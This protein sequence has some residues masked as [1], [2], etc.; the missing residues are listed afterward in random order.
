MG[1]L[2]LKNDRECL[3]AF[4]K[5]IVKQGAGSFGDIIQVGLASNLDGQ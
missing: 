5:V 2:V 4:S 1:F 3:A